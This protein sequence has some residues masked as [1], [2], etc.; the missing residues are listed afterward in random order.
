[1]YYTKRSDN[2]ADTFSVRANEDVQD[3]FREYVKKTDSN[4]NDFLSMLLTL[5][6]SKEVSDRIPIMDAA[7]KAVRSQ[8]E[9]VTRILIGVGESLMQ[10]QK[11]ATEQLEAKKLEM[12]HRIVNAEN[13]R[14]DLKD[15]YA[16]LKKQFDT[17]VFDLADSIERENKLENTLN[18]KNDIISNNR[19]K[20]DALNTVI[21]KQ[22]QDVQDAEIALTENRELKEQVKTQA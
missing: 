11:Q 6:A 22:K 1:M 18:D 10:E 15:Q 20:I 7:V 4:Q 2:V 14:N 8:T 19:D 9:T 3:R 17:K 5:F 12:D 21:A 16:E 13:E